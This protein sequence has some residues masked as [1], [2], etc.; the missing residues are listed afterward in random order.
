MHNGCTKFY[1][2]SKVWTKLTMYLFFKEFNRL[3][4]DTNYFI[5]VDG[6]SKEYVKT[7]HV[8]SGLNELLNNGVQLIVVV[9]KFGNLVSTTSRRISEAFIK[10]EKWKSREYRY[11][12]IPDTVEENTIVYVYGWFGLWNDDLCSTDRAKTACKSL[13]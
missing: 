2:Q 10:K 4:N 5:V 6:E 3:Y 9:G 1:Y 8:N 11:T 7:V 12:D 13:I